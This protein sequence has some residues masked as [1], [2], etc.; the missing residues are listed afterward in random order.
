MTALI[1]IYF[2]EMN[3]IP[4]I[5]GY[6]TSSALEI[7]LNFTRLKWHIYGNYTDGTDELICRV[8]MEMQI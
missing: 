5:V 6:K 2:S 3:H 7:V 1:I 8:A 4:K